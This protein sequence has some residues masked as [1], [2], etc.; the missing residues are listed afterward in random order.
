MALQ[1]DIHFYN[2]VVYQYATVSMHN[3]IPDLNHWRDSED[4]WKWLNK[5][6]FIRTDCRPQ[7]QKPTL[8]RLQDLELIASVMIYPSVNEKN[9]LEWTEGTFFPINPDLELTT[10]LIEKK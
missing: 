4:L 5:C 8:N 3:K 6:L 1:A 9:P 2:T 7:P 10:E